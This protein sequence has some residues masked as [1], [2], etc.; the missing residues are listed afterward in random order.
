ML[1]ATSF[2]LNGRRSDP[3]K[4]SS[5]P[6]AAKFL[7]SLDEALARRFHY[8][9]QLRRHKYAKRNAAIREF[10]QSTVTA[11]S[12]TGKTL[13]AIHAAAIEA[14]SKK[15]SISRSQVRRALNDTGYLIDAVWLKPRISELSNLAAYNKRFL[16]HHQ[17]VKRYQE[18][19]AARTKAGDPVRKSQIYAVKRTAE[20][21]KITP[22]RM[23][24]ILDAFEIPRH[25]NK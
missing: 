21:Y 6:M 19:V 15:F 2:R 7:M 25:R 10:W 20:E 23:R 8:R 22:G 1:A 12:E 18:H 3:G 5:T 11:A 13:R 9:G 14:A 16:S 24:Q 17:R 4:R